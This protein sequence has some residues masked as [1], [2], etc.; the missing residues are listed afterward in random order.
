MRATLSRSREQS[1]R[2]NGFASKPGIRPR[3][4]ARFP[5]QSGPSPDYREVLSSGSSEI[6]AS[7]A[8]P[9]AEK[10]SRLGRLTVGRYSSAADILSEGGEA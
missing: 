2:L 10:R 9:G 4:S 3:R 7:T 6:L 1:K 8:N 5:A